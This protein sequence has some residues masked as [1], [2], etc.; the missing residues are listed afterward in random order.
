MSLFASRERGPLIKLAL[1]IVI[2]QLGH[3]FMNV[4]DTFMVGPLGPDSIAG[5]GIG[6][7]IF[8]SIMV[9]GFGL[10]TSLDTVISQSAGAGQTEKTRIY[11]H[12]GIW[13]S[14]IAS[15]PLCF[16]IAIACHFLEAF[17]I[18]PGPAQIAKD[19]L[20]ISNASLP[21]FLLSATLSRYW[22]A[23]QKPAVVTWVMLIAN[24]LNA[25]GDWILVYGKWGFPALGGKGV[26]L[27][28]FCSRLFIVG[29]LF[30][31]TA[32]RV[33]LEWI[34]PKKE[35]LQRLFKIGIPASVQIGL[36]VAIFSIASVSSGRLGAMQAAAH[37][38]VLSIAS[39]TFM[40]PL[41][42]GSAAAV[43]VGF[44]LG[45]GSGNHA[46]A[47]GWEAIG[48]SIA[49][50]ATSAVIMLLFP[51][52]LLGIFTQDLALIH[53]AQ[54]LLLLAG[55]FQIFDG[56]QVCVTGA[57]RGLGETL[58]PMWANFIC[59]YGVT[60]GLIF[61]LGFKFGYGITGIWV[62]LASGLCLVACILL[63]M[64]DRETRK[65]A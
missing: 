7:S 63:W 16:L 61:I 41:G 15:I 12:Q 40:I 11:L 27:A 36:E 57:L 26:A 3:I 35:Y 39:F 33:Q 23:L 6:A 34:R 42:I 5:V 52:P 13:L 38:I 10:T 32:R 8:S 1:P 50:M 46:R 62:A 18:A 28:T 48:L 56:I 49:V 37:Q 14:L 19:F 21:L 60:L 44:H 30:T 17:K 53:I 45:K 24:L 43:R 20:S 65:L 25:L 58:A 2:A 4:V 47:S 55:L 22:Q 54:Q 31:Y 64:W 29:V 9:I 51:K 59:H